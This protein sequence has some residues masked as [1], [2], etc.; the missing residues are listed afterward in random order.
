[1]TETFSLPTIL[2]YESSEFARGEILGLEKLTRMVFAREDLDPVCARLVERM[3]ADPEDG[4]AMMDGSIIQSLIGN[5]FNA[6]GFQARALEIRRVFRHAGRPGAVRL[7]GLCMPGDFMANTPVQFLLGDGAVALDL[8]YL[9]PGETLP[10]HMPDHDVAMVMIGES[11]I[12]RPFLTDLQAVCD[13]WPRP[14]INHPSRILNTSRVLFNGLLR[15]LPGVRVAR[16]TTA[17]IGM[18]RALGDGRIHLDAL[19]GGAPYPI[20]VRPEDTHAGHGLERL[21]SREEVATYVSRRRPFEDT[22]TAAEFVDYRSVDGNHRKY[23][24]AFISGQPYLAHLAIGPH[25]MLHYLNADMAGN[26]TNR[27]E[28][29]EAMARFLEPGVGFGARQAKALAAVAEAV[30]LDYFGIDC[31]ETPDGDLLVFEGDNGMIVH[32]MDPEDVYPYKKP[33]MK[34]IFSAFCTMLETVARR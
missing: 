20:I 31:A 30:G 12:N 4:A 26:P 6:T 7:L 27:A 16:M 17:D 18:L 22:F 23:R 8:L 10:E 21:D 19:L 33:A 9:V 29:A 15:E 34:K 13:A 24:I 11:A 25:W 1:M 14:L 3:R 5:T 28:E 32:D 2:P